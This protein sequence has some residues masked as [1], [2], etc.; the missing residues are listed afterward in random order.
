MLFSTWYC[1]IIINVFSTLTLILYNAA[2]GVI[3][4]TIAVVS[5]SIKLYACHLTLVIHD[6]GSVGN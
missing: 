3:I 5:R 2:H 4:T 1:H 6:S